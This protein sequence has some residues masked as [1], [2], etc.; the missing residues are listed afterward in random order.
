MQQYDHLGK[1]MAALV[2]VRANYSH[3][4]INLTNSTYWTLKDLINSAIWT[5][6]N[7]RETIEANVTNSCKTSL[8]A[9]NDDYQKQNLET[10]VEMAMGTKT[11]RNRSQSRRRNRGQTTQNPRNQKRKSQKKNKKAGVKN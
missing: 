5:P 7:C 8:E 10:L 4:L 3:R 11:R 9:E 1:F 2:I 6:D